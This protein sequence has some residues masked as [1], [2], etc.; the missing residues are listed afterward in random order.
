MPREM[1]VGNRF[2]SDAPEDEYEKCNILLQKCQTN[3]FRLETI[4]FEVA[5]WG[6]LGGCLPSP[7][8]FF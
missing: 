7:T 1:I 2:L 4:A 3:D 8:I 5:V 6:R